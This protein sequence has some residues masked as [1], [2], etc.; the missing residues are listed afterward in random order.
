MALNENGD[1]VKTEFVVEGRKQPLVE[2]RERT[3]RSQEKYMRQGA[4]EEYD[5]LTS[6]NLVECLKAINEY[7]EGESEQ[8]M[9][10]RLKIIER[11][12]YLKVWHDLST[13][14]NHGHFI[15]VF[16]VSSLYDPAIHYLDSEYKNLTGC[17]NIDIQ[18]MV[19]TPEIYIVARSGSSDA[20]Q[21]TYVDTRLECLKDLSLDVKTSTGNDIG[22]KMRYFHGDSPA[23]QLESGQQKGGNFYCSGFGANA[24]Q[25]YQLDI[26]FSCHY[27]SL[28]DRQQL[29]LAGPLGRKNSLAKVSKPFHNLKKDELIRELNARGIYEG[30]SK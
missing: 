8:S 12:R 7:N 6:E 5:K 17:K 1:I 24:Q 30:E 4:D 27:L 26:C 25:A 28:L 2:I 22:D 14:A 29:V 9:R 21:L 10:D 20:E 13:I 23:R 3:L 11:T 18:T 15:L 19:E 16:M